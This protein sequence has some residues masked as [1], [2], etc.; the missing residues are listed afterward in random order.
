MST[1]APDIFSDSPGMD[2]DLP[3]LAYLRMID[4]L[5]FAGSAPYPRD[6]ILDIGAGVTTMIGDIPDDS[7]V[8]RT[9]H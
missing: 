3:E 2:Y 7:V 6:R 9:K 1:L 8:C 4:A 5:T